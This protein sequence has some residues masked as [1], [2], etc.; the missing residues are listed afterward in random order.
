[1]HTN[2]KVIG[3]TRLGIKSKCT[4]LEAEAVT[5]RL[6]ELFVEPVMGVGG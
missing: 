5:T 6:S 3:L 2:F 1:M 4:A